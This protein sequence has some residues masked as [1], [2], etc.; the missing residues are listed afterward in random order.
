MGIQVVEDAPVAPKCHGQNRLESAQEARGD[1]VGKGAHIAR[2][3]A[4]PVNPAPGAKGQPLAPNELGLVKADSAH[5]LAVRVQKPRC[6]PG[7]EER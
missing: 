2:Q 4:L 3:S 7:F 1:G 6:L 5:G